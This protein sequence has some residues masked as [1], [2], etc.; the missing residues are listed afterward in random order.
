MASLHFLS[1][2]NLGQSQR[3]SFQLLVLSS[4]HLSRKY[5]CKIYCFAYLITHNPGKANQSI[6]A[7]GNIRMIQPDG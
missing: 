3:A 4:W 6:F 7:H 5:L 2:K 1:M